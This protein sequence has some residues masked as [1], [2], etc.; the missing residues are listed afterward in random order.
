MLFRRADYLYKWRN[1]IEATHTVMIISDVISGAS[2]SDAMPL[3]SFIPEVEVKDIDQI[4]RARHDFRRPNYFS[5]RVDIIF[6]LRGDGRIG[7]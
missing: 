1:M 4:S 6:R 2:V 7:I 5:R 3:I